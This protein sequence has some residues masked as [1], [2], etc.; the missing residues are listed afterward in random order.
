MIPEPNGASESRRPASLRGR[1][2]RTSRFFPNERK[3]GLAGED[4]E[5]PRIAPDIVVEILSP[6]D[7]A[8]RV[9]SKRE[10]YLAAGTQLVIIVDPDART[11]DAYDAKG[12]T[13]YTEPGT[14]SSARFPGLE[15]GLTLLFSEIDEPR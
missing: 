4:L 10:T 8:D 12:H 11:L 7:R 6:D 9:R 15:I 14:F 5:V 3:A 13:C 1:S 2:S